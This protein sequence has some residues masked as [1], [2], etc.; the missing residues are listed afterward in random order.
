MSEG[1]SSYASVSQKFD[2]ANSMLVGHPADSQAALRQAWDAG[3]QP[4]RSYH[5]EQ[6]FLD[7]A[8]RGEITDWVEAVRFRAGI[9]HDVVYQHVDNKGENKTGFAPHVEDTISR[10]IKR[11]GN[12][13]TLSDNED[14]KDDT[15]FQAALKIFNFSEEKRTTKEGITLSPFFG[16]N[17]FLS[18]LYAMEQAR[19]LGIPDKYIL[20]EMTHIQGTVP[21]EA[22]NHFN[23]LENRLEEANELLAPQKQLSGD[24]I[25]KV[26]KS[27]VRMANADVDSFRRNFGEFIVDT[28]NLMVENVAGSPDHLDKPAFMLTACMGPVGFLEGTVAAK[29]PQGEKRIFHAVHG[30]PD[31]AA[32]ERDENKGIENIYTMGEYLRANAAAVAMVTALHVANTPVNE[33]P[34]TDISLN[35]LLNRDFSLEARAKGELSKFGATALAEAKKRNLITD[36]VGAY[37]LETLGSDGIKELAQLANKTG[38]NPARA[39][40]SSPDPKPGMNTKELADTFLNK[41]AEIF[42]SKGVDFADVRKDLEGIQKTQELPVVNEKGFDSQIASKIEKISDSLENFGKKEGNAAARYLKG[43]NRPTVQGRS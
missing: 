31:G 8:G 1:I 17:E 10:Y 23:T 43:R 16:Q 18:A 19:A 40:P 2:A 13:I 4:I 24:E 42:S 32:M 7:V 15:L 35:A 21:F 29:S 34:S 28:R 14:L 5:S 33:T 3:R 37:L 6:H 22:H 39:T 11:S 27:S 38:I 30:Q 12:T 36:P 26:I 41:A 25:L 9:N 20:A